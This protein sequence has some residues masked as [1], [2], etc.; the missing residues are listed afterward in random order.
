MTSAANRRCSVLMETWQFM[1]FVGEKVIFQKNDRTFNMN[2]M[3]SVDL[4][5]NNCTK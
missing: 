3:L 4:F 5:L 2:D 1:L